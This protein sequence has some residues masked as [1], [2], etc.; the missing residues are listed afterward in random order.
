[1][2]GI[3]VTQIPIEIRCSHREHSSLKIRSTRKCYKTE[4]CRGSLDSFVQN[5]KLLFVLLLVTA[6][7][8]CCQVKKSKSKKSRNVFMLKEMAFVKCG[9]TLER[10]HV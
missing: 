1:M 8:L 9:I 5:A 6:K 4:S 10:H 2:S 3:R 7:K